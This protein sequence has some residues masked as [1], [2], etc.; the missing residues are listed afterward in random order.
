VG[1]RA[2][3]CVCVLSALCP[4]LPSHSGKQVEEIGRVFAS[5][6][7]ALRSHT[8]G[9]QSNPDPTNGPIKPR[10][11]KWTN[12]TQILQMDQP[13]L[14]PEAWHVSRLEGQRL[15]VVAD[16]HLH[17]FALVLLFSRLSMLRDTHRCQG[18]FLVSTGVG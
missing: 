7:L 18:L 4:N 13:R 2:C 11:Y 9:N 17:H 3:V 10:S 8:P 5:A 15:T 12:Q 6:A 1:A 14:S 16:V